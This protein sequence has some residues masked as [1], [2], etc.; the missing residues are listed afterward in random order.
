[1]EM[2]AENRAGEREQKVLF[3]QAQ[4]GSLNLMK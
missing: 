1:V 3:I 4:K 2:I